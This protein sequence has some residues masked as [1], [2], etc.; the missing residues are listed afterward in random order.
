MIIENPD[1]ARLPELKQL[2]LEAF[3]SAEADY[4]DVFAARG[5]SP[6]RCRCIL[7]GDTPVAA[8][9]WLD[10]SCRGRKVAYLYGI[11][12]ALSHRGRG[13]CRRLMADTHALL[14][15]EGYAGALLVPVKGLEGMYAAM[16]YRP[17]GGI[18]EFVCG[19]ENM[20]VQLRRI[21]AGEYARL[22]SQLLPEGSVLQ[23]GENLTLLEGLAQCYTG[24]GF[25]L[26]AAVEGDTLRG[27]ELLGDASVA[28]AVTAALGCS[29]GSFRTPGQTPF[30]MY[31]PLD[32]GTLTG[33]AY[34]GLAFD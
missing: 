34:F 26:A 1:E 2:W 21:T 24:Q 4:Y 20:P 15:Q 28:P 16:G 8:L 13:L 31:H 27:L 25:L 11:A 14:R 23:E 30:A 32:G 12:T 19:P 6:A 7:E 33:P 9:Y 17:F 10:C 5:F 18:R 29:R 3:G 22:R